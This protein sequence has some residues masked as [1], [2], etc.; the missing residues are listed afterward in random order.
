MFNGSSAY[1]ITSHV[2]VMDDDPHPLADGH[3]DALTAMVAPI[4]GYRATGDT[5][6]FNLSH[7]SRPSGGYSP[8]N[9][10]RPPWL[11]AEVTATNFGLD[12]R[13]TQFS[14]VTRI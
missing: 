11:S 10:R 14:Y 8:R 9:G 7:R 5:M 4:S 13:S 6:G 3:D 12:G 2:M 1:E